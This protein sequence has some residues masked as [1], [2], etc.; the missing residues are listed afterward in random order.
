MEP[1]IIEDLV[2][3]GYDL[4]RAEGRQE[5][6]QEGERVGREVGRLAEARAAVLTVLGARGFVVGD[7]IARRLH[8]C[9]D[10]GVFE[11]WLRRAAVA[12]SVDEVFV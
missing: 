9:D 11:D 7:L 10:L 2:D 3:Y 4:G 6:R 5:G 1:V 8:D 12:P